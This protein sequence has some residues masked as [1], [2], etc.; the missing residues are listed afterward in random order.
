MK[1]DAPIRAPGRAARLLAVLVALVAL[2]GLMVAVAPAQEQTPPF[3]PGAADDTTPPKSTVS[4]LPQW[5]PLTFTVSWSGSDETGGSGLKHFDIQV[6]SDGGSWGNWVMGTIATSQDYTG[7][8]GV[9]YEFRA[10]AVDNAGNVQEW[11][12]TPQAATTV[13][14]LPPEATVSPLPTLTLDH[15]ITVTWSGTDAGSGIDHFDVEYQVGGGSWKA[16]KTDTTETSGS[17]TDGRQGTTYGFRARAVDNAG[18]EQPWSDDAQVTTT[19]SIGEPSARVI[20]FTSPIVKETTFPVEWA[21]EPP[22]GASIVSYD[23]QYNFNGGPWIDWLLDTEDTT[24]QFT[25]EQGDGIYA[26]QARARDNAGRISPYMGSSEA[27]IA[28]D[29][30]APPITIRIYASILFGD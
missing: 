25:A 7:S 5:S 23:I 14:A 3:T 22:P 26:F 27:V 11:S 2:F 20:P 1:Y 6:R 30:V 13:D 12:A 16:F 29:A 8:D 21:G 19:V 17:L 28:V 4:A 24:A 15:L 10:R 18:N 9:L